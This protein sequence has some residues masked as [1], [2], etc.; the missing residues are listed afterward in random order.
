MK[1]QLDL[2]AVKIAAADDLCRGEL[3]LETEGFAEQLSLKD[4]MLKKYKTLSNKR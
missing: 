2:K 1:E 4:Y 3:V